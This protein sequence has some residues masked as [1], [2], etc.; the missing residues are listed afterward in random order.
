MQVNRADW[1]RISKRGSFALLSIPPPQSPEFTQE[2][3]QTPG[4]ACQDGCEQERTGL[5]HWYEAQGMAT[6]QRSGLCRD[7]T[8][9]A[10]E[11]A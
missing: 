4:P 9:N 3:L 10:A 2:S 6:G 7:E 8:R 5:K 1:G 11:V